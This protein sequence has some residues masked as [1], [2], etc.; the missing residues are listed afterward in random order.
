MR[1]LVL[2]VPVLGVLMVRVS[3]L[4]VRMLMGLV[5][6]PVSVVEMLVPAALALVL[7]EGM[8]VLVP[9]KMLVPVG[10]V[11]PGPDDRAGSAHDS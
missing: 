3:L 9:V 2:T 1:M 11:A 8:L 10:L 5:L 4:V 6:V 7:V